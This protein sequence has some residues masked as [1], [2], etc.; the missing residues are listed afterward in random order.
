MTRTRTNHTLSAKWRY[1]E[2]LIRVGLEPVSECVKTRL[3]SLERQVF[4]L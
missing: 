1:L 2:S 3:L 4:H